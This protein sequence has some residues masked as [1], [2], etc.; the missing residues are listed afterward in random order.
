VL[1]LPGGE[2]VRHLG[3]QHLLHHRANDLAKSIRT[4]G[5]KL[6]DGGDRWLSFNLGHGGGS[7]GRIR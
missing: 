4:L 1:A 2:R 3:F 7:P 5:E 6:I